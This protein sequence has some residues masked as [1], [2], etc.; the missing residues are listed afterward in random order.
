M[1]GALNGM[2]VRKNDVR[3]ASSVLLYKYARDLA[4]T[5]E[6]GVDV[7]FDGFWR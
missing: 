4:K 3:G 2:H 6:D 5:L 1:Q 7:G